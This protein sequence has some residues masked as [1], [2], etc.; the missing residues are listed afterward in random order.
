MNIAHRVRLRQNQQIIVAAHLAV[1]GI[2]TRTAIAFLVQLQ[3]LDH[4]A[5]GTV[6]HQD[7]LGREVA[8]KRFSFAILDTGT[9]F[10]TRHLFKLPGSFVPSPLTQPTPYGRG[11]APQCLA[12]Q[13]TSDG[14]ALLLLPYGARGRAF[15]DESLR[16][17]L[18]ARP[19]P[20]Q[21]ADGVDEIG[22]VHGVEMKIADA[23]IHQIENLL[24]RDRC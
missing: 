9:R 7:A 23:A 10:G 4:G 15:C 22:P 12:R 19:Q 3:L 24:R 6:E 8:K 21:M 11:S 18:L 20:E 16:R 17:S 1:P 5:H 2:E 14:A 13:W